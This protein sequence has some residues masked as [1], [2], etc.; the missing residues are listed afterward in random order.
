[1]LQEWQSILKQMAEVA[2]AVKRLPPPLVR[3]RVR[4][5]VFE[6]MREQIPMGSESHVDIVGRVPVEVVEHQAWPV[7]LGYKC[8]KCEGTSN[9]GCCVSGINWEPMRMV[10]EP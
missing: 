7:L 10:K 4:A 8:M 9:M 5:D 1:M 6:Q 3:I 2:E